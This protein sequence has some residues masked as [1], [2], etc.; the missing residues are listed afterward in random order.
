M[1]KSDILTNLAEQFHP[2]LRG[3]ITCRIE[4]NCKHAYEA[5]RNPSDLK[6]VITFS[7]ETLDY[8]VVFKRALESAVRI[9]R[10]QSLADEVW[11]APVGE[12]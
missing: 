12:A 9:R 7:P 11:H 10:G 1:A 2:Q 5:R 4:K 6:I 8:P 3:H